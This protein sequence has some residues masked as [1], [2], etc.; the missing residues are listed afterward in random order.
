[1]NNP[2][3]SVIVT[4]YNHEKYIAECLDSI[5]MQ[6]GC[7]DFEV[8]IGNDC[9]TDGT[10]KIIDDYANKYPDKIRVLPRP[11]NL[12]MLNNMKDCFANANGDFIAICEGDDYWTDKRKLKKQYEALCADDKA[13]LVFNDIV[14]LEENDEKK[15]LTPHLKSEKAEL[16]NKITIQDVIKNKNPIANFSC[17]MYKK[18]ALDL[19]PIS[20]YEDKEN[21]D[22]L[23]N[24]YVLDKTEYA[25]FLKDKMSVY[26]I[27]PQGLWSGLPSNEKLIMN[28]VAI[29]K[30]NKI[31]GDKY[32]KEFYDWAEKPLGHRRIFGLAVS[33]SD[34]KRLF[35]GIMELEKKKKGK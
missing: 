19:V 14:L 7:P 11:K 21:A 8:I 28:C 26:R 34:T 20:Y 12:G 9:S 22:F 27:N 17:C 2:V 29:Y 5:L 25:L 31:F 32:K 15:K 23:F 1:M 10:G 4:T 24:L 13:R 30:C 18:E 3:V 35:F 6:E 16:S 33:V